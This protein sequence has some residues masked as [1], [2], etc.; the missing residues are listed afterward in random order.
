MA[1]NFAS[2]AFSDEVKSLQEKY[3]SRKAYERIERQ[4]VVD[5][6][7]DYEVDSLANVT[8]LYAK[9]EIIDL[10]ARPELLKLLTLGRLSCKT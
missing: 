9:A 10:N 4:P 7:T 3:G 6:L 5:G 8:A 2:P 1:R